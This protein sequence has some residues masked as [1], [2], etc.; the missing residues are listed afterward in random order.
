MLV[1]LVKLTQFVKLNVYKLCTLT[2]KGKYSTV[3]RRG[4]LPTGGIE[5]Y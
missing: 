1:T 2:S 3:S 4:L 5:F